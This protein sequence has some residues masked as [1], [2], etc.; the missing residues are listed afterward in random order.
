VPSGIRNKDW[1]GTTE[2]LAKLSDA[3]KRRWG[4]P[5]ASP[6]PSRKHRKRR[7]SKNRRHDVERGPKQRQALGAIGDWVGVDELPE[8]G[9]LDGVIPPWEDGWAWSPSAIPPELA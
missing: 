1:S 2:P 3:E 7:R 8:P 6:K 5:V 4:F 9:P